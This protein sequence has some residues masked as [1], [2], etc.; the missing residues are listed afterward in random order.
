[1]SDDNH[2]SVLLEELVMSM[3]LGPGDIAIDCT[4]G[5]GGHTEA[6]LD[7]I[8]TDGKI[9]GIDRD[10]TAHALVANRLSAP[11]EEGRLG[12]VNGAFSGLKDVLLANEID[13]K[14]QGICADIGVS[15]M[16]LDQ[17][18]RGFS[19]QVDGPLDMR[20]DQSQGDTAAD[21]VNQATEEVLARI[22]KDFGEEPKAW[23]I[24][25]KI[26][27]ERAI[28]PFTATLQLADFVKENIRYK[29]KSKKHPA[30]RVFQALRIA[31][32]N[33]LDELR[34]LLQTA[35]DGL[36]VG[37]RLAIIS[38]HSLEDRIVKKKFVDL[39]GRNQRSSLPRDIPLIDDQLHEMHS[40]KGKII[41]PFPLIPADI[42]I[43]ENPRARSAK[44]R[45]IEKL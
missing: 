35:F 23:W 11:I 33:E 20:M 25:K 30:T 13:G 45:V 17:A 34:T 14:V 27:E 3:N 24:A 9:Y 15:S 1:V 36:K 22:F 21:I 2:R 18:D 6:M 10:E 19:F 38:F 44:L 29:T 12:L 26:V 7:A 4:M 37:G 28:K 39:T 31:V 5:A 32:N 40:A 41:K 16:H 43:S 42:E 8:G